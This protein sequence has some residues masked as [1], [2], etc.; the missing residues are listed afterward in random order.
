MSLFKIPCILVA[1]VGLQITVTPPHPP[2]PPDE[3]AASTRLEI[4]M[5]QRSGPFAVGVCTVVFI[6]LLN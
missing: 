4:I 2:P 1:M 6:L 5:K 3:K